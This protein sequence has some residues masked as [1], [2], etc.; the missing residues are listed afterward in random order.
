MDEKQYDISNLQLSIGDYTFVS[1]FTVKYLFCDDSHIILG[2]SWMEALGFFIL[3]TKK[4]F[5]AFS[6]KK[7]KKTLHDSS[8]ESYLVTSKD[9]KD[10]SK[11]IL[12]ENKKI[13]AKY[14]KKN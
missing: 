5:L 8:L 2:S 4:K 10:I 14:A 1:Q 6:Y 3:N 7:K 11:V 9:F 13:N 12:Q